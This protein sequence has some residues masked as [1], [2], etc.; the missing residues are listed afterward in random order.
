MI[1][2]SE[3]GCSAEDVGCSSAVQLLVQGHGLWKP[4]VVEQSTLVGLSLLR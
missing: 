1:F 4:M 2:F 3:E